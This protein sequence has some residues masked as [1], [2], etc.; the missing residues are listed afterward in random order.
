[1]LLSLIFQSLIWLNEKYGR[2]ICPTLTESSGHCCFF[3]IFLFCF[4]FFYF[5][6]IRFQC[7]SS[8]KTWNG[9]NMWLFVVVVARTH[10]LQIQIIFQIYVI[11]QNVSLFCCRFGILPKCTTLQSEQSE[12]WQWALND[13]NE[14]VFEAW[15][16]CWHW[17]LVAS[18]LL[19]ETILCKII[20]KDLFWL[21]A[22][23][24]KFISKIAF[25]ERFK[26]KSVFQNVW[27]FR[28]SDPRM[29]HISLFCKIPIKDLNIFECTVFGIVLKILSVFLSL[30]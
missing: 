15:S 24:D 2:E 28:I 20:P 26:R 13:A 18:T 5:C 9:H 16:W 27:T 25:R 8:F 21:F 17:W 14:M 11:H 3:D 4:I 30:V 7:S 1:V 6:S 22:L 10:N 23:V 29:V 12:W 19:I